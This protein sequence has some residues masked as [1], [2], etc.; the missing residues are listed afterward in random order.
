MA[1]LSEMAADNL[2]LL[3]EKKPLIHNI[4]NY[5]VMNYTANA[6]LAMGA[7]P[8]MAHAQNEVED[9]VSFAGAL[10]LN[11]G[12]LTD[13]WIASMVKAGIKASALQTPIILD[14]VGSGAT[15]LRT[16]SAKRIIDQTKISVIRGNASEIL[17]LRHADSKTKGV[18]SVH[19]VDEAADTA[20][21]LA[22][23]LQTTL[24]I[25]GP[26]DLITDGQRVVRVSNGHPLMGYVTGTGCTATTAIGAFLAVDS[27]PVSATATA[28]AFFG[29]AG[30]VAGQS[31]SAPG[32]FMIQML[33]ALYTIT[34][35][36][37]RKGCKIE[38]E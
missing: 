35:D 29:L 4:T 6:L 26:V 36:E 28:L 31:A 15:P 1:T 38:A 16:Q 37:L 21:I 3:R 13:D 7:S 9:M 5:V 25:T 8:V 34:P 32:S 19:S 10:V 30:E 11:I 23:E 12:T 2:A 17:S 27:D 18:D 20:R 14:P 24:A 33:D 22:E